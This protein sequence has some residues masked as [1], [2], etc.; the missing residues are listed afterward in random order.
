MARL[1]FTPEEERQ[2]FQSGRF[3][4]PHPRV[5]KDGCDVVSESPRRD[6]SANA[7]RLAAVGHA[8]DRPSPSYREHGLEGLKRFDWCGR[9]S[10][11]LEHQA[12]LEEMF[13]V[14]PPHTTAEAC[15]RI[16]AAAGVKRGLTQTRQFL[17][18]IWG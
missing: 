8:V 7:A 9:S 13:R 10:E 1:S 11:L 12:S 14:D 17:K 16:Q 6:R 15:Q 3:A 2:A 18:K 5:R 4:H